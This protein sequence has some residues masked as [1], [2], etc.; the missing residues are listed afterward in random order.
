MT[1][2]PKREAESL[3]REAWGGGLPID[4]IV[5]AHELGID[6]VVG[7]LEPGVAGKISYVPG[8]DP[9]ISLNRED[10]P[11][12]IRFT[13]GHELGHYVERSAEAGQFSFIDRRD[14]LASAGIDLHEIFANQFAA[15]LLMPETEVRFRWE[16]DAT[17]ASLAVT[18]RVSQEAL[19][20]RLRNLG[21]VR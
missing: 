2:D 20:Y 7:Y 15:N 5:I 13:C 16:R 12:R 9:R 11:N 8:F 21:L 4:P 17:P 6:V 10:S 14:Y 18:F 19:N 3:L 1:L